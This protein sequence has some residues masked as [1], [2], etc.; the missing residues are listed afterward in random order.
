MTGHTS[1][2]MY[3]RTMLVLL[4]AITALLQ[5]RDGDLVAAAGHR[6]D[7]LSL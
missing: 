3:E 6:Q 2:L 1:A 7:D 5:V 4:M